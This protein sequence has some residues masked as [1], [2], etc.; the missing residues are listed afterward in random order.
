MMYARFLAMIV[1][2]TISMFGLMYLNTF[3][4]DHLFFSETRSYMALYMGAAMAII[5]LAFMLSM[6]SNRTLNVAIFVG[7]AIVFVLRLIL[8][9]RAARR[10][11]MP[12]KWHCKSSTG[13]GCSRR[14]PT[15]PCSSMVAT[16]RSSHAATC[17]ER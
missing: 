11:R 13:T 14:S 16:R 9:R 7:A 8:R 17:A 1:I 12:I 4:I 3:A 10:P 2:S 15:A 6:F 5:M